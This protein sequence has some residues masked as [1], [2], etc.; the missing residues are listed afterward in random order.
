M[1]RTISG[2][3]PLLISI[4]HAGTSIPDE[5]RLSMCDEVDKLRDTD[6]YV[7]RLYHFAEDMGAS[8]VKSDISRY[9]IDLNRSH[10]DES[11]YPG[12]FTTG[13]CP[14]TTFSGTALYSTPEKLSKSEIDKRIAKYWMPYHVF[15]EQELERIKS[16]HGFVILLDAHSIASVVP[17]LFAGRL[18]DLN[19]GTNGGKSCSPQLIQWL[20]IG[21]DQRFSTILNGRFKGGFITRH[22]GCPQS[23]IHA[24]QLEISQACYMNEEHY[25]WHDIKARELCDYLQQL[26]DRLMSWQPK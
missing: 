11:L 14:T 8:L 3:T 19:F 20:E 25:S 7:D 12:R 22:Y 9:V 10:T 5:V 15:I 18:D 23:N 16:T 6:W 13:L 4:P 24:I 17:N 21:N 1:I 2:T 26:C